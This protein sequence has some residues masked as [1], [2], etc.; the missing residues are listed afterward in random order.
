MAQIE[1]HAVHPVYGE[2]PLILGGKDFHAITE[3]VAR[4]LE[5][6]PPTG[7]IVDIFV[8]IPCSSSV[9]SHQLLASKR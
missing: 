4:P 7:W 9:I 6:K 5:R 2:P 8:E 1:E 3:A